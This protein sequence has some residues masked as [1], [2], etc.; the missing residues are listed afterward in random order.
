MFY[1]SHKRY[2]F[3]TYENDSLLYYLEESDEESSEI[4]NEEV[5]AQEKTRESLQCLTEP[6]EPRIEQLLLG[7]VLKDIEG[8]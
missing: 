4:P 1:F 5:N 2:L 7:E 8:D 3:S 6:E